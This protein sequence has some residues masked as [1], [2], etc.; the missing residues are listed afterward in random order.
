MKNIWLVYDR[1]DMAVWPS[2]FMAKKHAKE[3]AGVQ[4]L[5]RPSMGDG[6]PRFVVG[7]L[8][9]EEGK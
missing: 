6:K 9:L 4:N 3:R 8:V 2:C 7:R 1:K 5:I